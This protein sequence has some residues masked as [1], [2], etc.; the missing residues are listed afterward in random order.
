MAD[1]DIESFSTGDVRSRIANFELNHN[2]QASKIIRDTSIP[3]FEITHKDNFKNININCNSGFYMEVAKPTMINL[4]QSQILPINGISASCDDITKSKD[5][6]GHE[7]NLTLFLS[8]M[9][10]WQIL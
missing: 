2:K 7:F 1:G 4:S 9:Q 8:C 6:N 3:Y 5:T 10:V